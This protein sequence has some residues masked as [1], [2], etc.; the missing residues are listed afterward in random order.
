MGKYRLDLRRLKGPGCTTTEKKLFA[1][2]I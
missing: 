2:M 1:M